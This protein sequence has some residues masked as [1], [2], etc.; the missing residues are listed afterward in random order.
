MKWLRQLDGGSEKGVKE[1]FWSMAGGKI[2]GSQFGSFMLEARKA[3]DEKLVEMGLEPSRRDRDRAS[4]V[5]FRR[6]ELPLVS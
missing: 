3:V 4:E 2:A 6:L 1:V 5:N